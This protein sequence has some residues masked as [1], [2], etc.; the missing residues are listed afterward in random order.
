[1]VE[2]FVEEIVFL[3]PDKNGA[4]GNHFGSKTWALKGL[5]SEPILTKHS[6]IKKDKSG[7]MSFLGVTHSQRTS[8]INL[9]PD[10]L[11]R[12]VSAAVWYYCCLLQ[13][14]LT[15]IIKVGFIEL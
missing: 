3:P 12:P 2:R 1:L 13:K 10:F 7:T 14:F 8:D 11:F 4:A 9:S 15:N 5:R 6:L